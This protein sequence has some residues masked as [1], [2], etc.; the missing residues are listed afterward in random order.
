MTTEQNLEERRTRGPGS[1][2]N[3]LHGAQ[4][5]QRVSE[6]LSVAE[7]LRASED[8]FRTLIEM[9]FDGILVIEDGLIA[10]VNRGMADMLG[11]STDEMIGRPVV[12]F[13]AESRRE[14]IERRIADREEGTREGAMRHKDGRTI[15]VEATAQNEKLNGLARRIVAVRDMTGKRE[16]ERQL[17]QAQKMEAIGRLA[18][19]VAHDFNNLLT[20]ISSYTELLLEATMSAD[21]RHADLASIREAADAAASLTRQLLAFSRQQV[22]E[23]KNVDL[24]GAVTNSAKLLKRV[25]G[26]DIELA[27]VGG[28]DPLVV[29]IDPGQLEQ[30][31]MNLAVNSRDA[32]PSGGKL[33]IETHIVDVDEEYARAHRPAQPGRFAMLAVSDTGTGMDECTRERIFE[34]FFTT[35]EPG[36]GT[37]LGLATAYGIVTQSRGFIWVYSEPGIGTQ[38]KIYLPLVDEPPTKNIP[39][40]S[41]DDLCGTETVLVVED[42]PAV[43]EAT[44]RALERFGYRVIEASN[45]EEALRVASADDMHFDLLL[46]D[47]VMPGMGGRSVAEL[48]TAGHPELKVLF[49]SGYTDDAIVRQGVL[50]ATTPYLQK[51]FSPSSLVRKV[52]EAL[53]RKQWTT[54]AHV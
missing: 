22:I 17:R 33:T 3:A 14:L 54:I 13:V 53:G 5:I 19:G 39:A 47:I 31:I 42:A 34:P 32:M 11:Y 9:S 30:V 40:A 52:R 8:R 7:A 45:G 1:E 36:I 41:A 29:S 20:V 16:L 51:P 15:I 2:W 23:P 49:M 6:Q 43:R 44:R 38:F 46:T 24:C 27:L 26:E 18:G 35:K 25:I 4:V 12:D 48:I 21:P 28:A 10:K 37:G 50:S